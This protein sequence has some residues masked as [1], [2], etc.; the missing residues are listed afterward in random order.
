MPVVEAQSQVILV[1]HQL[2]VALEVVVPL[3]IR[4]VLQ[5]QQVLV[6]QVVFY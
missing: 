5:V 1:E 4:A 6:V 2:P 3:A